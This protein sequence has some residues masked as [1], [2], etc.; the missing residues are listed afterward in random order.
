MVNKKILIVIALV[1][2]GL[3]A[4][5]S[6]MSLFAGQHS[7]TNIDATGNQIDCVKCHGD[8]NAELAS[9]HSTVTGTDAPHADFKCEYCHRIEAGSA[10]GDNAYGVIPY[11]NATGATVRMYLVP[12]A[13]ME[14]ANVPL[15]INGS[16]ILTNKNMTLAGVSLKFKMP[17]KLSATT[18]DATLTV[19]AKSGW[20]LAPTYSAAT[21]LPFDTNTATRY[22]GLDLSKAT[23]TMTSS[24]PYYTANLDGAGSRAVNP[25]TSYHA[26]SLVSC[27]ECHGGDEPMG[28]YSRV[29]D[30]TDMTLGGAANCANCHYGGSTPATG[31]SGTKMTSLWAGGFGLTGGQDTGATEAHMGFATTADIDANGNTITRQKDGASN[32]ACIACH[33]HVAVDIKYEKALTYQFDASTVDGS[34]VNGSFTATGD[35]TY[36]Y[37]G[38]QAP[39]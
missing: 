23:I 3:W 24:R 7:F 38:N 16:D 5:P 36:T 1:G 26:A 20:K 11:I 35:R 37:S 33:T 27:L 10:S 29:V 12:V 28:H 30:G 19:G 9:G 22:S 21:G 2:I 4:L 32:G 6:T 39:R 18:S 15:V 13:D 31:E 34:V 8:V 17:G 25:G 14:A